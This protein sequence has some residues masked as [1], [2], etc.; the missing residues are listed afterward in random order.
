MTG[1]DT[2]ITCAVTLLIPDLRE[3]DSVVDEVITIVL[4][5]IMSYPPE[6]R[7]AAVERFIT[8]VEPQQ[9]LG[10]SL[11]QILKPLL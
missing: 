8:M 5:D 9:V 6:Q 7:V 1:L 10:S 4:R 2:L 11:R 3:D